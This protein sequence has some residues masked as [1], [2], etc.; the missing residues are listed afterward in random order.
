MIEFGLGLGH[1]LGHDRSIAA[2]NRR[3]F[4][5]SMQFCICKISKSSQPNQT[6]VWT[7]RICNA[8][9]SIPFDR[10]RCLF[11]LIVTLLLLHE[12][13]QLAERSP[14]HQVHRRRTHATANIKKPSTVLWYISWIC[15]SECWISIHMCCVALGLDDEAVIAP[16]VYETR[17]GLKVHS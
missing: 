15:Y 7:K 5:G 4:V 3:P 10:L 9:T 16:R 8:P 12:R 17:R 13:N 6:T 1:G 11:Q 2:G 14:W